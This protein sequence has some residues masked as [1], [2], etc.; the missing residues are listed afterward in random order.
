MKR[1]SLFVFGL[2]LL[3]L[4][5]GNVN[6]ISL[7]KTTDKFVANNNVNLYND[8]DGDLYAAG[9]NIT[10]TSKVNG[11][12]IAA[13]NTIYVNAI[14]NHNI[15]MAG[16]NLTFSNVSANNLTVA[17]SNILF[18]NISAN[19]IYAVGQNIEFT[20]TANTINFAGAKIIISG[21]INDQS[22][23]YAEDVTITDTAVINNTLN[24]K[25]T[26]PILYQGKVNKSKI[27]YTKVKDL[28]EKP[29]FDITKRAFSLV[30]KIGYISLIALIIILLFNKFSDK[31]INNLKEKPLKTILLGLLTLV[32]TPIL[33]VV[34]MISVIGIPIVIITIFAYI[35]LLIIAGGFSSIALGKLLFKDMNK[36]LETF[37][38]VLIISILS[39]IPFI[40]GLVWL[41]C[42]GYTFGSI[43]L[44]FKK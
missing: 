31:A 12:I 35:S 24:V 40:N 10:I 20:G 6:A 44:L 36:Y 42:V 28:E 33:S 41:T 38:A 5:S 11:D 25:S 2:M 1:I 14:I 13:G 9:N 23:I 17:G 32:I 7:P 43:L 21:T 18:A 29:Q 19:N 34:T 22:T 15:R 26:K 8:V 27:V 4:S 30:Y 3:F 39:I 16:N 37:I